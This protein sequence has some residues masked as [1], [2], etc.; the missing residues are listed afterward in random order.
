MSVIREVQI[1]K[2][3]PQ[4]MELTAEE[5]KDH[6]DKMNEAIMYAR[7][8]NTLALK[9]VNTLELITTSITK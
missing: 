8:R 1:L 9:T 6:L 5:K 2:D 3:S 7:N 4:W